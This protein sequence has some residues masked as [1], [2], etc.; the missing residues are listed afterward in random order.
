MNLRFW[1]ARKARRF[2]V[3]AGGLLLLSAPVLAQHTVDLTKLDEGM[4]GP[5][6]QVLVLGTAHLSEVSAAFN[7]ASLEPVLDRLAAYQPQIITVESLSGEECD[8]Y[9]RHPSVYSMGFCASTEAARAATGLDVPVAIASVNET[10]AN[11]PDQ[12]SP[13]QRRELASLFLAANDRTSALVQW[14]QLPAGERRIGDGLDAALVAVLQQLAT[15]NNENYLV[16]APLA[17]RLGLQRVHAVD[18][19]TGDNF[20]VV[21]EKA[22]GEA[23]SAAWEAG[24]P[25]WSQVLARREALSKGQDMLALYR[26]HNSAETLEAAADL[27]VRAALQAP[28]SQGY[29]QEWVAGWEIRNL[30]MVANIHQTFRQRPGARVLSIVGSSHKPWLDAWLGQMQGV[31]IVDALKVLE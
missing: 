23:V 25:R 20:K 10:L 19:H 11:W 27:N 18:D 12:P 1:K 28:S 2:A 29:P 24:K 22:F 15:R 30:R 8:L 17:A 16:A 6:T 21:D 3:L 14:L 5:R 9:A 13:A 31:D 7:P 26:H 4:S